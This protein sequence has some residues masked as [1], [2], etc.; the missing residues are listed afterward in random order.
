MTKNIDV[1]PDILLRTK[2]E[3]SYKGMTKQTKL[4]FQKTRI[5]NISAT[6]F[7]ICCPVR[8]SQSP[9]DGG[10]RPHLGAVGVQPPLKGEGV[11]RRGVG[12][13]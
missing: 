10:I 8:C 7:W 3:Q 13:V 1:S 12:S 6:E 5:P 9:S 2:H 4:R 11:G